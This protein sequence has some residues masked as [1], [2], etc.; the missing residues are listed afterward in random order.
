MSDALFIIFVGDIPGSLMRS[1]GSELYKDFAEVL[2]PYFIHVAVKLV[3][4]NRTY[5]L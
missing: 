1:G 5:L 4:L 3:C 2:G